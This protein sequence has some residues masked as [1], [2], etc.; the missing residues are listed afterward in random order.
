MGSDAELY[1]FDYERYVTE[2]VPAARQL[3]LRGEIVSGSRNQTSSAAARDLQGPF[4][5]LGRETSSRV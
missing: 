1:V 4:G 5:G 2:M 3:L